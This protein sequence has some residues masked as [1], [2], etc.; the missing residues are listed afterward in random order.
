[1][2]AWKGRGII[3]TCEIYI[4]KKQK[5]KQ[6]HND[7]IYTLFKKKI[8]NENYYYYKRIHKHLTQ[9]SIHRYILLK[10]LS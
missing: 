4:K 10:N 1:M 6:C 3:I 8:M 5:K 2:L 7:V 9:H